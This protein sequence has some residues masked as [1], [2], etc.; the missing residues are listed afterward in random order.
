MVVMQGNLQK[1]YGSVVLDGITNLDYKVEVKLTP[2]PSG[3]KRT[4]PGKWSLRDVL[5]SVKADDQHIFHFI[6]RDWQ[7][8]L[9]VH[10][11]G[12]DTAALIVAGELSECPVSYTCMYLRRRGWTKKTVRKLLQRSFDA[13]S[14]DAATKAKWDKKNNRVIPGRSRCGR[15]TMDMAKMLTCGQRCW[16]DY[17]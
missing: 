14:A 5:M 12:T 6:A 2:S 1:S 11:D 7:G 13:E 8:D 16:A 17:H 15:S 4:S 10:F 3:E 9:L